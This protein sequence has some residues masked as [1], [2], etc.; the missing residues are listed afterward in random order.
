MDVRDTGYE[1]V[2]SILMTNCNEYGS[3]LSGSIDVEN[4]LSSRTNVNPQ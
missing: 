3:E 4:F 2:N 1:D